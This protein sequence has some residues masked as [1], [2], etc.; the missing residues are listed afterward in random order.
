MS[1]NLSGKSSAGGGDEINS[2]DAATLTTQVGTL[3]SQLTGKLDA[4]TNT[5]Q[6]GY[7]VTWSGTAPQ[8]SQSTQVQAN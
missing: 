2:A 7:A 4:P 6:S 1:F 3:S 8:W 5:P